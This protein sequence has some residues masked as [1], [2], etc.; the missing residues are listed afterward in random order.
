M[1]PDSNTL[2]GAPPGPSGSTI[3][4][5]RLFGLIFRNSGANCFPLEMFIGC[6]VYGRPISSRATLILRPF[7]VFQV[8]S[9]IVIAG[10]ASAILNR[11]RG[12]GIKLYRTEPALGNWAD[13]G[14]P[15]ALHCGS[16]SV[17]TAASLRAN[18]I[19][20]ACSGALPA[21]A[22][23][24]RNV[25]FG[26]QKAWHSLISG[27]MLAGYGGGRRDVITDVANCGR[28]CIAVRQIGLPRAA[29]YSAA[30][31]E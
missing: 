4:G 5:M 22:G 20:P 19:Y 2:I 16:R 17:P 18:P 11:L 13:A 1:A 31:H 12:S 30:R 6:T 28:V 3:A 26:I 24:M 10:L 14:V 7:G 21:L 9:S 25:L 8:W 23:K 27:A 15:P 29:G